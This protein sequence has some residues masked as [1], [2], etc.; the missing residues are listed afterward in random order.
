MVV[1]GLMSNG[2]WRKIKG[3]DSV[4][5]DAYPVAVRAKQ[6]EWNMTYPGPDGALGTADDFTVRSQLHVVV[7][8]PTVLHATSED[9]IHSFFV[10]QFRVKQD[11]VP[12]MVI[13]V[14]FQPTATGEY[15]IGCAELCG[16]GHYKMRARVFVHTAEEFDAWVAARAAGGGTSS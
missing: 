7:N 3:R 15:E 4:P 6:F 10:P 8:R 5:A 1:L 9:V 16:M 11:V 13:N 12:G 2:V 14:W